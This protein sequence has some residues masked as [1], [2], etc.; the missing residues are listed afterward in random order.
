MRKVAH[1]W[2]M[3][4]L[5]MLACLS[6]STSNAQMYPGYYRTPLVDS[7]QQVINDLNIEVDQADSILNL[8]SVENIMLKERLAKQEDSASKM[9]KFV[10]IYKSEN[11]QL[12]QTNKILII[13]NCLGALLLLLSLVYIM[14]G[15]NKSKSDKISST[16]PAPIPAP[17]AMVGAIA[18]GET[19]GTASSVEDRLIQIE[20][21]ARLREGGLLTTHEFEKEKERILRGA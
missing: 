20:R 21:L 2:L 5:T 17:A 8:Q 14:S 3:C 9:E 12:D 13:F 7:L 11:V 16:T 1:F 15:R 6:T 10:S 4:S 19:S 18:P